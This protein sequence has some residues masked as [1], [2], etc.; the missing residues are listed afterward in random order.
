MENFLL[1]CDWGTSSF[2]LKL[3]N[4]HTRT[5]IEEVSSE[6]EGISYVYK[7]WKECFEREKTGRRSF[8]L[9][10]LKRNIELLANKV[11]FPLT[12]IPV[13]I[14]GMAC[15]SIGIKELPY[16]SLPF[17][18][19][20]STAIIHTLPVTDHFP[21]KT[22]LISGISSEKEVMRGEETQIMGLSAMHDVTHDKVTTTYVFPGTHSKHIEIL[23]G[24][25]IAFRTYITG[26]LFN[27][28]RNY[29]ILSDSVL[30]PE[31]EENLYQSD[32][33]AFCLGVEQS[34]ESNLLNT[35]FSVRINHLFKQ[36]SR[37]ENFFYLSG[38]LIGTE[39]TAFSKKDRPIV[40][41]S[42]GKIYSLYCL[43]IKELGLLTQ[44]VITPP[45]VI[46]NAAFYGHI[47][48]LQNKKI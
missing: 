8:Y 24:K 17:P 38:L 16:A 30:T 29:S 35:L 37:K 10:K 28:L 6:T 26:E 31:N 5:L 11:S 43:A 25:I 33:D 46:E 44:T 15:S 41:C 2:R 27:M 19:D 36:L 13:I 4:V 21:Y 47:K 7:N 3:V 40:L 20:G 18:L 22:C 34:K 39:L 1:S 9:N 42:S 45:D 12:H 23:D 48:V 32:R 14:S